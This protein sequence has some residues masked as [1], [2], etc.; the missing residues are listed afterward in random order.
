MNYSAYQQAIFNEVQTGSGNLL[1]ESVAGSGKTTTIVEA[2]KY[3]DPKLRTLF[4]AFNRSIANELGF[5]VPR[6]VESS[7]FNSLGFKV[8]RSKQWVKLN[9]D[10]TRNCLFNEVLN[11]KSQT[12]LCWQ[13]LGPVCKLV[14]LL[15]SNAVDPDVSDEAYYVEYCKQLMQMYD[16]DI[17]LKCL[18]I[19]VR[20]FKAVAAKIT[21][22]DFDDQLYVPTMQGW[23]QPTYDRIFVDEAQDLN[24]IQR[25]MVALLLKPEGRAVFVGDSSQAIYGFRGASPTSM[26]DIMVDFACKTL[27]L[28]ISYRCSKRVVDEARSIVPRIESS[29]TAPEGNV[30][31]LDSQQFLEEVVPG[32]M[33]LCRTT[34]PL[35]QWCLR[36]LSSNKM[37]YI[38]GHDLGEALIEFVQEFAP[39]PMMSSDLVMELTKA[40]EQARLKMEGVKLAAYEDRIAAVMHLASSFRNTIDIETALRSMFQDR[41]AGIK[42]STIHKAKGLENDKVFLVCPELLPHPKATRSWELVQESNLKYVAITR[43]RKEFVYVK[44]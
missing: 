3:V 34:A 22:C 24:V 23:L 21:V 18:S 13:L 10:K 36:L 37:T 12:R 31:T 8:Y 32:D 28:S 1:I 42:L 33:V 14:S 6:N 15:R 7:T 44:S 41:G 2:L 5:R 29:E 20:T 30:K 35:V 43:A 4:L 40:V 26:N 16:I 11:Y 17:D 38:Q 19:A 25:K 9:E 27:P 39:Q